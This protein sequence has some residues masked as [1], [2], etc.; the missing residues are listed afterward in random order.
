MDALRQSI[1]PDEL[2]T[3][4]KAMQKHVEQTYEALFSVCMSSI[5]MLGNLQGIVEEQTRSFLAGRLGDCNIGEMFFARFGD[6]DSAARAIKHIHEQAVPSQKTS[7]PVTQ[8]ICV[9]VVPEG[10]KQKV[11]QQVARQAIPGK[12]IDFVTSTEEILVYREWPRF[13]LTSLPQLSPQAED[14][15]NQMQIAGPGMTH[16][17]NDVG[18]WFDIDG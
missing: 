6:A 1:K 13:P 12:A 10:E 16:S 3:L 9:L 4:D 7:R 14:A 2:R 17:R 18:K 11:F 8:E 5:N 15:Y